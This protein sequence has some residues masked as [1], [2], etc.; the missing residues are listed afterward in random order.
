MDALQSCM[1]AFLECCMSFA[2]SG[3]CR[4]TG[5]GNCISQ[6]FSDSNTACK[7][8][9]RSSTR[10]STERTSFWCCTLSARLT[11]IFVS[12][13][14]KRRS[15]VRRC[16]AC[17]GLLTRSRPC[18]NSS[19]E[20]CPDPS[21]SRTWNRSLAWFGGTPATLRAL[22]TPGCT[23]FNSSQ[24]RR[25]LQSLSA[26]RKIAFNLS[27]VCCSCS[28][29]CATYSSSLLFLRYVEDVLDNDT[30]NDV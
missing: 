23:G 12:M 6:L 5:I 24:S 19:K 26:S 29:L 17:G 27:L 25:P 9:C 7:F 3:S 21:Q 4:D 18:V 28:S 20:I 30:C 22:A 8:C 15:S 16:F 14:T 11:F 1:V 13:A 10:F 2:G